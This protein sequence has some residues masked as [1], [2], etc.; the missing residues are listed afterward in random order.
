MSHHNPGTGSTERLLDVRNLSVSFLTHFGEVKAVTDVSYHV[1]REEVIA[2][3]G[4]SGCGKSV[5]Q[6]SALQLIQSPPGRVTGNGVLF[7]GNDLLKYAPSSR[8]MRAIR[9]A[10]ISMIFQE[11][12]TSLNPV[13]TI[14]CQLT[15][16]IRIHF[17]VSKREALDIGRK[18]LAAVGIPDPEDRM[19][20]YPFEMSGGMRQRVLIAVAIACQSKLIIADEPTTAL[21]VTTQAQV[22]EL[23]MSIVEN[24]GT[25]L[26]IVT[27]N[28][29]LVSRYS[30][31]IYVMYAGRIVESGTTHDILKTPKHPYTIGLLHS[32]PRLEDD[33]HKDLVP[34]DGSP[35]NLID[36][37]ETCSFLPRCR[38]ACDRCRTERA[39]GLREAGPHDHSTA[40][41]VEI[42]GLST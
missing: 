14:G 2:I 1:N 28:L 33:R 15:D 7:E 32:V 5:S 12:M 8:E 23:L 38:F 26:V 27:H 16:V 17:K 13:F 11:P 21:D 19:R 24:Y 42:G 6:L 10:K 20:S 30:G 9:G 41:Y 40:C 18:A 34:I 35:P 36:L 3:V 4:E 25:S 37:A 39:P 29:G 22:M 31:R